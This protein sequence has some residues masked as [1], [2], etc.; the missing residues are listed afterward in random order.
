MRGDRMRIPFYYE[1]KS[2]FKTSF[3]RCYKRTRIPRQ[4]VASEGYSWM[5]N[6]MT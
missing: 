2:D 6:L 5:K 3:K 1:T 4:I